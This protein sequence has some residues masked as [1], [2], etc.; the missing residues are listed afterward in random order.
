MALY[1]NFI[2][3]KSGSMSVIHKD[4]IDGFNRFIKEQR[5]FDGE[6]PRMT[7]TLFDTAVS[8]SFI[9]TPLH[10]VKDI[11][12]ESYKPGGNTAL[13]DA[14]GK[15]IRL[16]EPLVT[17][18]DAVLTVIFTDGEENSSTEWKKDGLKAE[19]ERKSAE[20]W[21]FVYL[22]ANVDAFAEAGSMG[23][24]GANT[25]GYSSTPMGTASAYTT[26]STSTTNWRSA[27]DP[28][29]KPKDTKT[30]TTP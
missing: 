5:A 3:D 1:I 4:V 6:E 26:S 10:L 28:T 22:G 25:Y 16:I 30:S 18:G 24:A 13:L 17:K 23:V 7:L 14:V 19:I 15:T 29:F 20:G 8:Q 11:T 21:E 12:G 9:G 2:L 27:N